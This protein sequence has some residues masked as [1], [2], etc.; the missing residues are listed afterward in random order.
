LCEKD[1]AGRRVLASRFPGVEIVD[2]VAKLESAGD[3]DLVTAGF[4]CQDLSQVGR[5]DGINGKK[6]GIV[7][8]LFRLLEAKPP[9]WVL[10]ENV[11]FMLW[12]H[13]GAAIRYLTDRLEALGY[14]WAYRVID[15]RAF[16]LPQRRMRVFLLASRV[17]DPAP[18]LLGAD[19][20]PIRDPRP[21]EIELN[22]T[23]IGFY[24]TEGNRG[25]GWAYDAVPAL[26]PGSGKGIPSPPAVLMPDGTVVTPAIEDGESLQGF[27]RG[28]TEAADAGT[29]RRS[30]WKLVGNAVSVPVSH[31]IGE[32]LARP[33]ANVS[34]SESPIK[35]A[36]SWPKAARGEAGRCWNVEV[37]AY[38]VREPLESLRGHVSVNAMP[39]SSAAT[40]AFADR[41]ER[42]NL[43]PPPGFLE[44]LRAH[45]ERSLPW[46]E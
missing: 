6:S 45:C 23:P 46:R 20:L 40:G 25:G 42:S 27:P 14:R 9:H 18:I 44:A 34:F 30:R 21:R 35:G 33:T 11:Q 13:R 12:L 17:G 5:R 43:T 37:S 29:R 10:I 15:T 36:D 8:Q 7:S 16:G 24:W 41:L 2:D 32:R 38:P 22:G 39:L 1:L 26:K 3:V 28:W 4:P 19:A 31:W